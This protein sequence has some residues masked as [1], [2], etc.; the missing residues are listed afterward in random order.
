MSQLGE[1]ARAGLH[2][3]Q[4]DAGDPSRPELLEQD[5]LAH[6]IQRRILKIFQDGRNYSDVKGRWRV[7]VVFDNLI[8]RGDMPPTIAILSFCIA[9][10][11]RARRTSPAAGIR[12][13]ERMD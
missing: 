10:V 12:E 13:M 7:P 11:L 8:A 4:P 3:E 5:R 6:V 1:V 9:L 2:S